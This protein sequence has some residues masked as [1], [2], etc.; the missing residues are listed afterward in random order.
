MLLS[1][2]LFINWLKDKTKLNYVQP[3]PNTSFSCFFF[4]Y[5]LRDLQVY[6][7]H[8]LA[9]WL[10]K[11]KAIGLLLPSVNHFLLLFFTKDR[12]TDSKLSLQKDKIRQSDYFFTQIMSDLPLKLCPWKLLSCSL[13]KGDPDSKTFNIV[14]LQNNKCYFHSIFDVNYNIILKTISNCF[15]VGT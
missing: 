8:A 15:S 3:A 13:Q 6:H 5:K 1:E 11:Q 10:I 9:D 2:D 14:H 4:I 12:N 7:C